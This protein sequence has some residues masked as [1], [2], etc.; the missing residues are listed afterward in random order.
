MIEELKKKHGQEIDREFINSILTNFHI[1]KHALQEM[2]ERTSFVNL[3][4]E[5]DET[6]KDGTKKVNFTL[7]IRNI[8]EA[9]N[10]NVLA[11][12]NTD[13]SVNIALSDYDYFVFAYDESRGNWNLITFK[14]KSWYDKTIWEKQQMALEGFDRKTHKGK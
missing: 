10:K 11:Y 8:R 7:T 1:S 5:L 3:V 12:I 14:E 2:R 6:F 4:E 9:I 13:G